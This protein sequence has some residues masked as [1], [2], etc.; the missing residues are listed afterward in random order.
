MALD[1]RWCRGVQRDSGLGFL[2][3]GIRID[4]KRKRKG[5]PEFGPKL[6][7]RGVLEPELLLEPCPADRSWLLKHME[8]V[9]EPD[10]HVERRRII[11]QPP[12]RGLVDRYRMLLQ[13]FVEGLGEL[14][15]FFPKESLARGCYIAVWAGR[16]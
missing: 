5:I 12:N 1:D 16:S 10:I 3:P 4:G 2:D 7:R 13:Q 11:L 8:P 6:V 14:D 15:S 9:A